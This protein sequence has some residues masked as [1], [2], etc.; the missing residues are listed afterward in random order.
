MI[1]F[2][3]C[4]ERIWGLQ[5]EIFIPAAASRLVSKNQA[6]M[7]VQNG[8]EVVA[9]GANV[10]FQDEEIFY[11]PIAEYVDQ[12]AALITDFI[13]NCGMARTFAYLMDPA[14]ENKITDDEIFTDVSKT[15][16]NALTNVRQSNDKKSG[17]AQTAFKI[18]LSQLI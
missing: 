9:C 11:G 5:S 8:L 7:M 2:E 14:H 10:P 4:N 1:S 16:E 6:E 17:L 18:A 15:I 13:A 12:N 3:E